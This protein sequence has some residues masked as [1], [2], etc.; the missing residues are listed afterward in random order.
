MTTP[1]LLAPHDYERMFRTI[2]G[3]LRN[4]FANPQK[5]C[6]FFSVIGAAI[7]N[8]AHKVKGVSYSGAA[9]FEFGLG[10]QLLLADP[11]NTLFTHSINGFHS[12]IEADGWLIDLTSPLL[13]EL[14]AEM[15]LGSCPRRMLQ[16]PITEE[17]PSPFELS[18]RQCFYLAADREFTAQRVDFVLENPRFL[19]I[20]EDCIAS[21]CAGDR[22]ILSEIR[23]SG[24]W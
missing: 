1:Y 12:W 11:K 3:H 14:V 17:A 6:T 5:S 19:K 21:Y 9:A 7:L 18:E 15:K 13:P 22:R 10:K 20:V 8:E 4:H 2:H 23:V 16:R 24:N